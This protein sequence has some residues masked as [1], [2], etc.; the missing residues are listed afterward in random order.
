MKG[1]KKMLAKQGQFE[2]QL[3][4]YGPVYKYTNTCTC[5]NY[6][7]THNAYTQHTDTDIHM[8]TQMCM[9]NKSGEN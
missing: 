9:K 7:C 4:S 8:H 2:S 6:S 3:P 5:T 1:C